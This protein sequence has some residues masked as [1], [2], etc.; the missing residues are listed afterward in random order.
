MQILLAL[1]VLLGCDGLQDKP[2]TP[3]PKEAAPVPPPT[4]PE[5]VLK[6]LVKQVTLGGQIRTRAEY[7]NPTSYGQASAAAAAAGTQSDDFF[8]TRIRLNLKFTLNDDIEVFVQPQDQRAWGQEANVLT[9][10]RNLDLHQ[11]Y[12]DVR[13]L[14]SEPLS[15]RAGRFEMA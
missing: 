1:G 3:P 11:G 14:F 7:R 15:I 8:L 12:V 9:D 2:P 10:E 5:S 4:Q 13:N 6:T